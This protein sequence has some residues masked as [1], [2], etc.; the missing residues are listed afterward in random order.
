[1]I[2]DDKR[3]I[4][5]VDLPAAIGLLT[6]LP[7]VIDGDRAMARGAASAWA[8]PLVGVII[9]TVVAGIAGIFMWLGVPPSITAA[10]ALA[11]GI[12]VTGAMHED[13]LADSADGLWGGWDKARRLEIMKDSRIGVYGV[14]A[15]GL[16]LLIR[17]SALVAI[18]GTGNTWIALIATGALSRSAI[19]GAMTLLPHA[20]RDGL[21]KNVGRPSQQTF[22][23]SA[24]LGAFFAL[25]T[26]FLG[27][28]FLAALITVICVM[29]AKAK[30]NGQ[31]GDILGATQQIAE[32]S[33]LIAIV[34]SVT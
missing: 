1:M 16:S 18:I 7:V 19:V 29:I 10:L 33:I 20:R 9:G 11:G 21:S 5:R 25:I 32:M 30:I 17:W 26:G 13:G 14:V 6:R 34:V 3:L 8:Y 24:G 27:L 22:W 2:E 31:T 28:I 23:V 15:L 12:V 4:D